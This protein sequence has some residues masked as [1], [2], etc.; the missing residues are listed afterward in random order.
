MLILNL[1][2]NAPAEV[3]LLFFIQADDTSNIAELKDS[4]SSFFLYF[5]LQQEQAVEIILQ[6]YTPLLKFNVN[7]LAW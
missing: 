2:E 5:C 1:T 4:C 7:N 3:I 6:H